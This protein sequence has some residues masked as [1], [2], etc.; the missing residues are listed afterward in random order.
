MTLSELNLEIIER[1]SA[2]KE[3]TLPVRAAIAKAIILRTA[4][5]QVKED[6]KVEVAAKAPKK[7][8]K[9]SRKKLF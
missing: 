9:K 7:P 8:T 1:L 3:Q 5:Q 2:V 4:L 6:I